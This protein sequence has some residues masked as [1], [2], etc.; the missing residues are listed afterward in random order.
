LEFPAAAGAL[1]LYFADI[2]KFPILTIA[3]EFRLAV[4]LRKYSDMEASEK[5]VVSNL[6]FVVKIA[7]EYRHYKVK[8]SDLIQEGNIGLLRAVEKYDYRRG[9]RFST[10]ATWWIRQSITRAI[11]DQGR[12]IRVPVH[13]ADSINR[14]VR[15]QNSL[16]QRLGREPSMEEIAGELDVPV[17][18]LKEIAAIIPEPMSLESPLSEDEDGHLGDFLADPRASS[19]VDIL[20][21]VARKH[22]LYDLLEDVLSERERQV[23]GLLAQGLKNR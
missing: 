3:E 6:R 10:Y 9:Y 11:A 2:H 1:D 12:T 15:M 13:M 5:L 18:R 7:H 4:R 16:G 8:L 23:L 19:P 17:E 14:Y 22:Q 21:S 20:S